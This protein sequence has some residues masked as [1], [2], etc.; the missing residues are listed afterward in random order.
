MTSALTESLVLTWQFKGNMYKDHTDI[1]LRI[2]GS[3]TGEFPDYSL[4][5][6]C[7]PH[8]RVYEQPLS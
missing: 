5:N 4:G 8:S 3:I 6:N 7:M 2:Y 1:V